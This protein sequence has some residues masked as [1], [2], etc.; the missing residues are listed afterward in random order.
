[1]STVDRVRP[2]VEPIVAGAGLCLYDLDLHGG[3]LR[4]V[5]DQPGGVGMDALTEVTRQVSRALD[6]SDPIDGRFTLEVSSPGLERVLRT[7]EHFAGAV[8]TVVSVKTVAGAPGE[9]RAQG[10]LVSVDETG[11]TLDA[12]VDTGEPRHVAF[13]DI[14]RARTVFEWGPAPKPGG[15]RTP[16]TKRSRAA[17]GDGATPSRQGATL[18]PQKKPKK[19]VT[20]P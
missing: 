17:T 8:G 7:P 12:A 6:E 2:L 3:V 10:V 16:R 13:A 14:E 5:V 9:R 4:V 18:T 19:K 1:M 15:P 20:A 11:I